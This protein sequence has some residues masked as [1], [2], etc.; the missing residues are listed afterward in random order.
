MY[1][2][3]T[4]TDTKSYGDYEKQLE[5]RYSAEFSIS[6][7][8]S[9]A[10]STVDGSFSDL[11]SSCFLSPNSLHRQALS[12]SHQQLKDFLRFAADRDN[13]AS[14][15]LSNVVTLHRKY[16]EQRSD[17]DLVCEGS[18]NNNRLNLNSAMRNMRSPIPGY[19][20]QNTAPKAGENKGDKE[21]SATVPNPGS[22]VLSNTSTSPSNAKNC[23]GQMFVTSGVS[24]VSGHALN[25]SESEQVLS[26]TKSL[27][28]VFGRTT[29][30]SCGNTESDR[31]NNTNA[32]CKASNS[33]TKHQNYSHFT[34][35]SH[36]SSSSSARS[37]SGSVSSDVGT[38]SNNSRSSSSRSKSKSTSESSVSKINC[39]HNE[40]DNV[41]APNACVN[42]KSTSY[43]HELSTYLDTPTVKDLI[44]MFSEGKQLTGRSC[45]NGKPELT[46]ETSART[47]STAR[48]TILPNEDL[49]CDRGHEAT[50]LS[51][52][53]WS[54]RSDTIRKGNF[55]NKSVAGKTNFTN[56]IL[57]R[58]EPAREC[59]SVASSN[60]CNG[61]REDFETEKFV[62]VK[63]AGNKFSGTTD[64]LSL[65]AANALLMKENEVLKR[66]ELTAS[67]VSD[68]TRVIIQL[69]REQLTQVKD[70][71][72]RCI[73]EKQ[74]VE[75]RL[76]VS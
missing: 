26:T 16:R 2:N 54:K 49:E 34:G 31:I 21:K 28:E 27:T 30:N 74:E 12:V 4:D 15:S 39:S 10:S 55:T 66:Q 56:D 47:E 69:L 52:K 3:C 64:V 60:S 45:A 23:F 5:H 37:R 9:F 67:T 76:S 72:I 71:L 33:S 68:A 61:Q 32:V 43:N 65:K 44:R 13:T 20:T 58:S 75:Q 73:E 40:S 48:E 57:K 6:Q 38:H 42:D 14:V 29:N 1:T 51:T 18:K 36:G 17:D 63:A 25:A 62:D 70:D 24:T 7:C 22:R 50:Y 41:Q 19:S 59:Q 35:S 8:R 46:I 53:E 11:S